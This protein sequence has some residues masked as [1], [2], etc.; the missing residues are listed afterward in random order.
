MDDDQKY[1]YET[2]ISGHHLLLTGNAGTGTTFIIKSAVKFLREKGKRVAL[3]CSTGLATTL[4]EDA[5]TLHKW[6]GLGNGQYSN[7]ELLHLISND[8]RYEKVKKSTKECEFLF[9]DEI[10][11]ISTTTTTV[12]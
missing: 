7:G 1:A 9:I 5:F 2:I 11:M 8:E 10:S 3:T 6:A 12:I 4:Y